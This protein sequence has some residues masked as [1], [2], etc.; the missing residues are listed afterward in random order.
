MSGTSMATAVLRLFFA[1]FAASTLRVYP[2][3]ST[4]CIIFLRFSGR[5]VSS[6]ARTRVTVVL[7]TP[8]RRAI[9]FLLN[10]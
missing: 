6:P 2:L 1:R 10:I 5:T 9:S 7:D 3:S 4:I 8:A